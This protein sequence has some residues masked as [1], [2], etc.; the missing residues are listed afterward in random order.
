MLLLLISAASTPWS[1]EGENRDSCGLASQFLFLRKRLI[2]RLPS[3]TFNDWP[4]VLPFDVLI[5]SYQPSTYFHFTSVGTEGTPR[6]TASFHRLC[7]SEIN[8]LLERPSRYGFNLSVTRKFSELYLTCSSGDT[9]WSYELMIETLRTILH[10]VDANG[11]RDLQWTVMDQ[12]T[13]KRW[14]NCRLYLRN[15]LDGAFDTNEEQ[16]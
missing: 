10:L 9:I 8:Y 14:E 1:I 12:H 11:A 6:A 3:I 5:P 7:T 15:P 13:R 2:T 16:I 4:L